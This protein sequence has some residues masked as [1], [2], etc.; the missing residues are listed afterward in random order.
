[1]RPNDRKLSADDDGHVDASVHFGAVPDLPEH[2]R[3]RSSKNPQSDPEQIP[4]TICEVPSGL[5]VFDWTVPLEWNI[6][7]AYIKN[8]AGERVVD[9][10]AS[11]FACRGLQRSRSC[12]IGSFRAQGASVFRSSAAGLDSVSHVV[13]QADLGLLPA[14]QST[15]GVAGGRIRGMHRFLARTRSSDVR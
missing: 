11:Q 14:A 6:R 8:S 3:Q 5:R 2:H 10:R 7:D 4:L 13:L 15:A 9:F 1:M 12:A